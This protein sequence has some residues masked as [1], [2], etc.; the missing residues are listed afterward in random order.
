MTGTPSP[1]SEIDR[2]VFAENEFRYIRA[3]Y[4][5]RS[6]SFPIIGLGRVSCTASGVIAGL[7]ALY[8]YTTSSAVSSPHPWWYWMPS[9]IFQSTYM[10]SGSLTLRVQDSA[11]HG[12]A[13]NAP[14]VD[15][16]A[17]TSTSP[18]PMFGK[19]AH[20]TQSVGHPL[21]VPTLTTAPV[22]LPLGPIII[23][24]SSSAG[25]ALATAASTAA[26]MSACETP[27]LSASA[28]AMASPTWASVI[29]G[30]CCLR[31]DAIASAIWVSVVPCCSARAPAIALATWASV[32]PPG[33]AARACAMAS[34]TSA[35]VT[36]G[37]ADIAAWTAAATSSAEAPCC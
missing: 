31:A 12:S 13:M 1:R 10:L 34:A 8:V 7:P 36:P 26:W 20:Q 15:L 25:T 28:D 35:C 23:M 4:L 17:V 11:T 6:S 19:V 27:G 5:L 2:M 32:T 3:T 37:W 29:P 9:R 14:V 21:G 24:D 22:T 18:A 30:V 16:A 33:C